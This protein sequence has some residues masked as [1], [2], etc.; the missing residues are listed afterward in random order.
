[1][2]LVRC[3]DD[4]SI[5]H[6]EDVA[7]LDPIAEME[8]VQTELILADL[9]ICSK[10]RAKSKTL[11]V[12]EGLVW[13]KVFKALDDNRPVRS[14]KFHFDEKAI[15]KQLPMITAKP[16]VYACNVG[17]DDIAAGH[18]DLADNFTKYI[19]EV[20]PGTAVV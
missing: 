7:N 10:Y 13:E 9:S 19:N 14:I 17:P 11:T 2:H 4:L 8:N 15:V 6:V 12:K 20:Y 5:V 18:C 3:F 1:V 16:L